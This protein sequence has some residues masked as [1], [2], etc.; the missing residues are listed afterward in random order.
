M[1][2]G[3]FGA[4]VIAVGLLGVAGVFPVSAQLPSL[5]DKEVLGYFV[6]ADSKSFE[7][8]IAA[9]GKTSIKALDSKGVP[10]NNELVIPIVFTIEETTPDGKITSRK[11]IPE[12]L[13]SAQSATLKP[14]DITIKGKVTGE[15]G[16]EVFVTED[17]GAITLGGHLLNPA[18]MKNPTRFFIEVRIPNAMPKGKEDEDAK[19]AAKE[20][21]D[22]IKDDK[23]QLVWSDGK[24]TKIAGK[25]AVEGKSKEVT[26]PG[27]TAAAIE[28]GVFK[29][30]RI[31][32]SA[33]P[34]SS[35][36]LSNPSKRPLLEGF[37]LSWSADPAKD[38]QAKA[39]VTIEIK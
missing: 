11:I 30:R 10:V 4:G 16:F 25:E 18:E 38:P 6:A 35:M 29:E 28:F 22:K 17:R 7:F 8:R 5:S 21:A 2:T 33:T 26:G 34:N 15:I 13:E 12:S 1:K 23:V 3:D 24:K 37:S 14:K 27:I 39:R 36:Q 32:V 31:Q 9:D 19:K 20:L